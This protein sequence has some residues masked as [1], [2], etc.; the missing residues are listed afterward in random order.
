MK[1][2]LALGVFDLFHIGHLR[3]LQF[4]RRQGEHLSVAIC[5]DAI[6]LWGKGASPVIAQ[7]QRME[8]LQG[9]GWIDHV[10]L[11]PISTEMTQ[12]AAAWIE[13]W[14]IDC[15]VCGSE[16]QGSARWTRL[17]PALAARHIAVVYAPHTPGISSTLIA[18]RIRERE[19]RAALSNT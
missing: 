10:A 1:H 7:E 15:V 19:Q 14:G 12:E 2:V 8:I 6:A 17:E 13:A 4:A 3:Y 11:L 16:W 18:Q 9:L 5:P